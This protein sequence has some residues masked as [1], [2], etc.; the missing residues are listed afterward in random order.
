MYIVCDLEMLD[1]S[2]RSTVEVIAS[3]GWPCGG[4]YRC[5]HADWSIVTK[6]TADHVSRLARQTGAEIISRL[7]HERRRREKSGPA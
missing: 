7:E 4:A 6:R 3:D 5:R 1:D 2:W